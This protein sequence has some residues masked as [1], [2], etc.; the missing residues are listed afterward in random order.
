MS[1][2]LDCWLGLLASRYLNTDSV[3]TG[4]LVTNKFISRFA[5]QCFYRPA[6]AALDLNL[7]IDQQSLKQQ[8]VAVWATVFFLDSFHKLE[9]INPPRP[10]G[11]TE[12]CT[13]WPKIGRCISH[14]TPLKKSLSNYQ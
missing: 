4:V 14:Y 5:F 3:W 6:A 11:I 8:L 12:I 10:L 13:H 1:L 2:G 9:T 7:A